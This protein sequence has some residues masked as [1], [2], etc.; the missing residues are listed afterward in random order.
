MFLSGTTSAAVDAAA[1][2]A[3][4]NPLSFI[5]TGGPSAALGASDQA[6]A[7]EHLLATLNGSI[8]SFPTALQY[9]AAIASM[10]SMSATGGNAFSN[11]VPN[12]TTT[13]AGGD[14]A[15]PLPVGGVG[16]PTSSSTTSNAAVQQ[17]QHHQQPLSHE[18]LLLR[19]VEGKRYIRELSVLLADMSATFSKLKVA[20]DRTH[21][22]LDEAAIHFFAVLRLYTQLLLAHDG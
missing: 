8:A 4:A 11:T 6:A 5:A 21:A 1:N 9:S 14:A 13:T 22:E 2:S 12:T 10:H 17:Q 20:S 15:S 3:G 16:G 18:D 7:A 19:A